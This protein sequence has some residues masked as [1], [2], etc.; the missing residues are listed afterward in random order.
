MGLG[1]LGGLGLCEWLD[2]RAAPVSASASAS[3]KKTLAFDVVASVDSLRERMRRGCV[4]TVP[5]GELCDWID[6]GPLHDQA[7]WAETLDH[8]IATKNQEAFDIAMR[9]KT[10]TRS[11]TE[12]HLYAAVR[13]GLDIDNALY[14]TGVLWKSKGAR[15]AALQAA[16]AAGLGDSSIDVAP[17]LTALLTAGMSLRRTPAMPTNFRDL[18]RLTAMQYPSCVQPVIDGVR[19]GDPV[20]I[21]MY[22]D[23]ACV[24]CQDL[25]TV[26]DSATY[27]RHIE[28]FVQPLALVTCL[29]FPG[30]PALL[31]QR[32]PQSMAIAVAV[33][34]SK[35]LRG[36]YAL[37]QVLGRGEPDTKVSPDAYDWLCVRMIAKSG[38]VGPEVLRA[39][40]TDNASKQAAVKAAIETDNLVLLQFLVENLHTAGSR[41]ALVLCA[42]LGR[43]RMLHYLLTRPDFA[44]CL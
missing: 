4:Q 8:M 19:A 29:D 17:S 40:L 7:V 6:F 43:Q 2:T 41:A 42:K 1:S 15:E 24:I 5:R 10:A 14:V 39:V 34:A 27:T 18:V 38:C 11:F 21:K 37:P 33:V 12:Q 20:S 31:S 25:G 23:L 30:V 26:W 32:S 22:G 16:V 36:D 28:E 13:A 3:D 9:N 44:L 35:A